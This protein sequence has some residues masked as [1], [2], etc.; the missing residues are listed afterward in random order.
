MKRSL[1]L[2]L[3]CSIGLLARAE[4]EKKEDYFDI[5]IMAQKLGPMKDMRLETIVDSLKAGCTTELETLRALYAWEAHFVTFDCKAQ[6]NP[7]KNS[8]SATV[9][10]MTRKTNAEGYANLFKAMCDIAGIKCNVVAGVYRRGTN[11]IGD[12]EAAERQYWNVAELKG[13]QYLVDAC[14]GA[15][16]TDEKIKTFTTEYTDAWWLSTRTL[17]ALT[18][19]PDSAQYQLLQVPVTKQEFASAPLVSPGAIVQKKPCAKRNTGVF[20]RE[21]VAVGHG[22]GELDLSI[23]LRW[24]RFIL[25]I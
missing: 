10:L 22:H 23:K 13:T 19:F 11:A 5:D 15:G 16:Y 21:K 2:V 12:F 9:A 1:L 4:K 14:L 20:P 25:Y 3:L 24:Q 18:H 17:F 8:G 7:D 6:R